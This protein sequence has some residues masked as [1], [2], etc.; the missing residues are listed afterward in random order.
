MNTENQTTEQQN[1]KH[2]L[3]LNNPL[4]VPR[5]VLALLDNLLRKPRF[6]RVIEYAAKSSEDG[7]AEQTQQNE[8]HGC[9]VCIHVG[10]AC[11][12]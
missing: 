11:D 7:S 3:S 5:S 6:S 9:Q 1:P 4:N 8:Y 2:I 10:E 12:F